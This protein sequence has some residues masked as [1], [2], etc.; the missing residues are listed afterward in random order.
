MNL[1]IEFVTEWITSGNIIIT[2][3]NNGAKSLE[4]NT[5]IK[6]SML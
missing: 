2:N 1:N 4:N 5:R 3:D 6:G